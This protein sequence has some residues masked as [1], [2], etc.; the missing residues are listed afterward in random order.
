MLE[1]N[2]ARMQAELVNGGLG[3][4]HLQTL[5]NKQMVDV[6]MTVGMAIDSVWY[7]V[8]PKAIGS[9][10]LVEILVGQSGRKGQPSNPLF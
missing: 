5:C 2:L 3:K 8:H 7:R 6:K 4:T 9:A 1:A 10:F